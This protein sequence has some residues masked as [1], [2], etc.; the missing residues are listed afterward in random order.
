[1][2]DRAADRTCRVFVFGLVVLIVGLVVAWL[3]GHGHL[4][5][6][7]Q[8]VTGVTLILFSIVFCLAVT[9][10]MAGTSFIAR[11][12]HLAIPESPKEG[13]MSRVIRD[14]DTGAEMVIRA[15]PNSSIR[16]VLE[17]DWPFSR[18]KSGYWYV[19]DAR[20][21]DVTNWPISNWDGVAIIRFRD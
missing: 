12:K 11:Q 13:V 18:T 20:G 17:D 16:E 21:N 2:S 8:F 5:I 4:P 7:P 1:L 6:N 14:P 3:G 19:V 15:H 10:M 9:T